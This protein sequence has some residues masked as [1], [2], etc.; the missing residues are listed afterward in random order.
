MQYVSSQTIQSWKLQPTAWRLCSSKNKRR[1]NFKQCYKCFSSL[2]FCSFFFPSGGIPILEEACR[3]RPYNSSPLVAE[4]CCDVITE[5][6]VCE[7]LKTVGSPVGCRRKPHTC[8]IIFVVLYCLK[9]QHP[10]AF[11]SVDSFHLGLCQV[12]CA[13]PKSRGFPPQLICIQTLLNY[14]ITL[15]SNPPLIRPINSVSWKLQEKHYT[16]ILT[17]M[18]WLYF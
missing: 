2:T 3:N 8:Q 12:G 15:K 1:W 16:R 4:G 10:R 18:Q 6:L 9:E 7:W 17:K 11:N 5:A 14:C 13:R